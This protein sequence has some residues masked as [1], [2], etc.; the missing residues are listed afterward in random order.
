MAA[1]R[2]P[3][4]SELLSLKGS[5]TLKQHAR[6]LGA[7]VKHPVAFD[8]QRGEFYTGADC[9]RQKA[10]LD[11][12][13]V[14]WLLALID[15][16]PLR[17]DFD[18]FARSTFANRYLDEGAKLDVSSARLRGLAREASDLLAGRSWSWEIALRGVRR[19]LKREG[20][21]VFSYLRTADARTAFGL[22]AA[23]LIAEYGR[24]IRPCSRPD[25][26]RL[27][28]ARKGQAFCTRQCSQRTRFARFWGKLSR[29]ERHKRRH[30]QYRKEVTEKHGAAAA[31]RVRSRPPKGEQT[32]AL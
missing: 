1:Q 5:K 13:H 27:F 31:R 21:F 17:P 32:D 22:R 11:E 29:Q 4:S 26:G 2:L 14:T 7:K 28:L 23:E 24:L 16:Q 3:Q 6:R 9:A 19:V 20:P 12:L 8:P 15:G 30:E 18:D 10:D 25:C